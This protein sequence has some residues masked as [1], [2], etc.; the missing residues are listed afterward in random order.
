MGKGKKLMYYLRRMGGDERKNFQRWLESP[1]FGNSM[2]LGQIIEILEKGPL[3]R[4]DE[5]VDFGEIAKEVWEKESLDG[6]QDQYIAVRLSQ[7]QAKL[8]EYLVYQKGRP[9]AQLSSILLVKAC[10]DLNGDKYLDQLYQKSI[11]EI[12]VPESTEKILSQFHLEEAMNDYLVKQTVAPGKNHLQEVEASLDTYLVLQ[13]LKY[14]CA[15]LVESIL[16]PT[17]PPS[18]LIS[19]ILELVESNPGRFPE[20]IQAYFHAYKMLAMLLEDLPG[21]EDHNSFFLD[22]FRK[23]TFYQLPEARDIFTYAQNYCVLKIRKGETEFRK[24][25]AE[26]YDFALEVRIFEEAG[27]LSPFYYKNCVQVLCK[28]G[29]H[30]RAE[31]IAHKY[32]N[33]LFLPYRESCFI[34]NTAIIQ[35]HKGAFKAASRQLY[36]SLGTYHSFQYK[37]GARVYYCRA[38]W[39]IGQFDLLFAALHAFNQFIQRNR[40][41]LQDEAVRYRKFI[42][43]LKRMAQAMEGVPGEIEEKLARIQSEINKKEE[44]N[45]FGWLRSKLNKIVRGTD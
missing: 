12:G 21:N 27:K 23:P 16:E 17:H 10:L 2:Q 29:E 14:G 30:L 6:S 11:K 4:E 31:E 32:R 35:F 8:Y 38:L 15:N 26:L 1:W 34:Y 33:R 44:A 28:M 42:A 13:K 24:Q 9:N 45:L 25:L 3:A 36:Q 40:H 37:L 20:L 39:E 41:Q 18:L 19:A 43:Y 5:M 7:L 22:I